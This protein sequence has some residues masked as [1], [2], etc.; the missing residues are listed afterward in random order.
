MRRTRF[1]LGGVTLGVVGTVGV[2][3]LIPAGDGDASTRQ[4]AVSTSPKLATFLD[5]AVDTR[6]AEKTSAEVIAEVA[7]GPEPGQP[8]PVQTAALTVT[9]QPV[10]GAA[11][12]MTDPVVAEATT[13]MPDTTRE[14]VAARTA[15]NLRAGPST[16]NPTLFVLQPDEQVAIVDRQ[17]GWAKVEARNG[18][19]GWVYG[20]YL[21]DSSVD[22]VDRTVTSS[23]EPIAKKPK[24]R[25]EKPTREARVERPRKTGSDLAAI[26]LRAGPSRS[27]ETIGTVDPGTPLRIAERRN[28][29][30]RVVVPGGISGWVRVN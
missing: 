1:G 4:S 15:V 25:V 24:V 2:L 7:A 29:W 23:I 30:A 3:M 27:A 26:R 10:T 28:G 13:P 12:A 22:D 14:L 21:G 8:A 9:P 18:E 17:G 5:N 20:S 6:P 16:S 19:T 11:P